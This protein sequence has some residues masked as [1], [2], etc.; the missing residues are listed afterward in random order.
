MGM[1]IAVIVKGKQGTLIP[2]SVASVSPGYRLCTRFVCRQA[3]Y[4]A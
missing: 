2:Q 1:T 4:L 3:M